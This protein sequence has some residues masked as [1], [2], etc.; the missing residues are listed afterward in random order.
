MLV[1]VAAIAVHHQDIW[2]EGLHGGD[3]VHDAAA[4]I[5]E[6]ILYVADALDHEQA[7]LFGIHRLMVLVFQDGCIGANSHVQVSILCRL[8]EEFYV[9]TM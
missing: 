9:T 6:R 4:G 3:K 2:L 8:T 5:D 7:L 1:F